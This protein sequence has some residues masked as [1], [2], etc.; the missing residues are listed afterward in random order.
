LLDTNGNTLA[1]VLGLQFSDPI[2]KRF[3]MSL[4]ALVF[5]LRVLHL[6]KVEVGCFVGSVQSNGD[7]EG[8]RFHVFLVVW[9]DWHGALTQ[10]R[11]YRRVVCRRDGLLSSR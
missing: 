8:Y 1:R 9:F 7:V 11:Q 2:L 6:D 10:R 5:G 3:G 4:D